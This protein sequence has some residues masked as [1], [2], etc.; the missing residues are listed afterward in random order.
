MPRTKRVAHKVKKKPFHEVKKFYCPTAEAKYNN[1]VVSRDLYAERGLVAEKAGI[2]E[3]PEWLRTTIR[4]RRWE[5]FVVPPEPAVTELVREFYA[6][7]LSQEWPTTVIV[8]EVEVPFNAEAINYLFELESVQCSFSPCRGEVTGDALIEVM[9]TIAQH[10]STWDVDEHNNLR[11]RRTELEHDLKCLYSF[12]QTTLCP[13]SHDS[14]VSKARAFMLYCL[15][16]GLQV[17]VGAVLAQE[18]FECSQRGKGKLFLPA[19]ITALC[20]EAGVPVLPEEGL[21]HPRAAVSFGPS[22]AT[23]N[24]RASASSSAPAAPGDDVLLERF[25][26]FEVMQQ[27]MH[28]RQEELCDRMHSFWQYEQQRDGIMERTFKKLTPRVV[29]QFPPFPQQILDPWTTHSAPAPN[30][31]APNEDSE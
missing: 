25:T 26:Q 14:T 4:E 5:N 29:P 10:D 13:T 7:F 23:K 28:R 9:E 15:H 22:R 3:L 8:R 2:E 12:V 27:Q 6:N 16:K 17:D 11:F 24:P 18:I 21:L 19:T 20:R 1:Q 31:D 30:P